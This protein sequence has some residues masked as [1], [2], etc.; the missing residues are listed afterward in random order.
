M[1]TKAAL[2]IGTSRHDGNTWRVLRG[3]NERLQLPVFDL[4]SLHISYFDYNSD[5][6]K[7]DFIPTKEKLVTF[8]PNGLVSPMY[9]YSVSA[10]MKTFIDRLSDPLGPRKHLGRQLKGKRLFLMATGST[11]EVLPDCMTQM[12]RLTAN[13]MGMR[14]EGAHYS[15]ILEDLSVT[16]EVIK[17]ARNFLESTVSGSDTELSDQ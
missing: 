13:Y 6:L 2:V 3:A 15:R 1:S 8:E 11:E 4:A 9:W 14:Y 10:Q 12:I 7:D 17:Q 5:N 16:P